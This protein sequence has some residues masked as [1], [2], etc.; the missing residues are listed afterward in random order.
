MS[1]IRKVVIT[2]FGGPDVLK[3][4]DDVCP[5]PPPGHVQIATE[6]AGF[7]G[8]D[9]NMRMGIYPFVKRPP[10]TP[11]CCLVGTITAVGPGCSGALAPGSVVVVLTKYDADASLVN[12]PERY[13]VPV[14]A[15]VDRRKAA[16]LVCD[17]NSAYSMVV[18]TGQV[19]R[20]QR[21]FVHGLSGAVG[22]ALMKLC[23]LRGAE[24][25]G[26]ASER[27]HPEIRR[28]GASPFVYTNKAWIAHMRDVAGGAHAVFDALGFESFDESWSILAPDGILVGFGTNMNSLGGSKFRNPTATIAK[29]LVRGSS[30]VFS[31]GERSAFFALSRDATTYVS[32]IKTLLDMLKT[33]KIAVPIKSVWDLEDI[34]SAHRGWGRVE[35]V[36]SLLIKVAR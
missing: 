21:V 27:N 12:Q 17:W 30:P 29:L 20:G 35:G 4:I 18:Q 19:S 28:Q 24:V 33:G 32:N 5:P 9:V 13:C 36:G 8:T 26:T 3:V 34:R 22:Y 10:L 25:Y 23:Q 15:G 31:R 7:S 16:A 1:A 2:D 6:Y 14:P 11:G